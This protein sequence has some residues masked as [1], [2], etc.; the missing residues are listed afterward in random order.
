VWEVAYTARDYLAL[1]ETFSGH[2]AM[3]PRKR[4]SLYGEIRRRIEAR[5]DPRVR[6]HWLAILHVARRL[7]M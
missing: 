1:L 7:D 4:D 5:A 3:E 6:R 2:I